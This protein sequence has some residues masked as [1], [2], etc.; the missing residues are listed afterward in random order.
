MVEDIPKV[1]LDSQRTVAKTKCLLNFCCLFAKS[2]ISKLLHRCPM[3]VP[4]VNGTV[5]LN[6]SPVSRGQSRRVLAFPPVPAEIP[7]QDD[8]LVYAHRNKLHRIH[9]AWIAI[10]ES[11]QRNSGVRLMCI[12]NVR[13]N[14]KPPIVRRPKT[15]EAVEGGAYVLNRATTGEF[16]FQVRDDPKI[17]DNELLLQLDPKLLYRQKHS[18]RFSAPKQLRPTPH[19]AARGIAALHRWTI[20]AFAN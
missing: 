4:G 18:F 16:E 17:V 9:G 19:Q 5:L 2:L 10:S 11:I 1:P 15:M 8:L 12:H 13:P 7:P 6:L 20:H 3:A 14:V